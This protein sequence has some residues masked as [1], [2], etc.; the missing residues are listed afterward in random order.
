VDYR[1]WE[2]RAANARNLIDDLDLVFLAGQMPD[3]MHTTL[4]NHVTAISSSDPALRVSE[5]VLLIL[6]SPQYA[7]Q[8]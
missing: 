6:L 8:R 2:A 7:V 4:V 5:A 3:A 1:G